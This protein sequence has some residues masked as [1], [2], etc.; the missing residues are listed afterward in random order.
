MQSLIRYVEAITD[1]KESGVWPLSVFLALKSNEDRIAKMCTTRKTEIRH[2]I[3]RC[4]SCAYTG[5]KELEEGIRNADKWIKKQIKGAC[6]DCVR[7]GEPGK[8]RIAH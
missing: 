3:S 6:L 1:L 4:S 2:D 8:C 5:T 7:G